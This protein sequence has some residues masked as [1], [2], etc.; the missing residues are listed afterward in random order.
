MKR[1]WFL[2]ASKINWISPNCDLEWIH[3]GYMT[4]ILERTQEGSFWQSPELVDIL[5]ATSARINRFF[6]E[7]FTGATPQGSGSNVTAYPQFFIIQGGFQRFTPQGSGS[8]IFNLPTILLVLQGV[9]SIM[10]LLRA[11]AQTLQRT[12]KFSGSL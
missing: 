1:I 6:K 12:H 7:D 5:P 11:V 4:A 10:L 2:I 3:L 9:S 8:K